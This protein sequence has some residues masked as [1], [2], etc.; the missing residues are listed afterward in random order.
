MTKINLA[1]IEDNA[2]IL[3]SYK[4]YFASQKEVT[5]VATEKSVESFLK[6]YT[7][8]TTI[9]V[10]LL[11]IMLEGMNGINGI[12]LIKKIWPDTNIIINSV[13]EDQEN[14]FNALQQGAIGYLTKE[15]SLE[16]IK[17]SIIQSKEGMSI[18][19]SSIASRII[20]F[21]SDNNHA[22]K[23]KLTE[24][25]KIVA[26]ALKNGL[27]Y[28]VIAIENGLSLDTIRFHVRNIYKK[29]HIN[30]KGQLIRMMM[31]K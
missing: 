14:I 19:N 27:S 8:T 20:H 3:E 1:I 28:K 7:A 23:E 29:L 22:I 26:E 11:D 21:F 9:D 25:E 6:N 4:T 2:D 13:L 31:R 30:S 24:K 18:M 10:L 12:P 16:N 15:T 17:Q 5:L